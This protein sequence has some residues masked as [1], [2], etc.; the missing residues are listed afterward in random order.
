MNACPEKRIQEELLAMDDL[1]LGRVFAIMRSHDSARKD[2]DPRKLNVASVRKVSRKP[3]RG[4]TQHVASEAVQ[5]TIEPD[6]ATAETLQD[7]MGP[8][9]TMA[10]EILDTTEPDLTMVEIL[11]TMEPNLLATHEAGNTLDEEFRTET[12][13][14]GELKIRPL[15]K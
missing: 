3:E 12:P 6:L 14:D 1:T 11:D 8:D 13:S 15:D 2:S 9:L 5:E 4:K 7:M 10:E